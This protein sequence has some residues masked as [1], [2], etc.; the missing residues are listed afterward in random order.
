MVP[1]AGLEPARFS[2]H[3]PQTCA[4]TN[5]ATWAKSK[6]QNYGVPGAGAVDVGAAGAAVVVPGTAVVPGEVV[7]G[8]GDVV[9][10]GAVGAP[11]MTEAAGLDCR[12]D[13]EIDVTMK[14]T[15]NAVVSLCS[16]VVAPRAP[17]AVCEP[18]PPKAPARSAPLPC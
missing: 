1:K 16:S 17:T 15:K 9:V 4:S 2:P 3:A 5:S 13:K 14:R 10:A 8:A 18:P 11:L 12:T 7:V 6:D